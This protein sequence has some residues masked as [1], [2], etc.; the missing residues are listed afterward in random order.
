MKK[1]KKDNDENNENVENPENDENAKKENSS[2]IN[3]L[4]KADEE[5]KNGTDNNSFVKDKDISYLNYV[6]NDIICCRRT[7]N[8]VIGNSQTLLSFD[9][10]IR[11]AF[12][13]K[14]FS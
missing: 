13:N 11:S 14:D 3:V 1:L 2:K 8:K 10:Y 5:N 4:K 6:Y 9:N 7:Y 12:F